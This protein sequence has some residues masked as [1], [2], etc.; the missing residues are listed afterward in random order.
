VRG[1]RLLLCKLTRRPIFSIPV[2]IAYTLF[3]DRFISGITRG[4]VK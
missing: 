3:L 4:A 1:R 2:T